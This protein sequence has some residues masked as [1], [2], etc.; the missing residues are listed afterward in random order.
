MERQIE[1][2]QEIKDM[3]AEL[4]EIKLLKEFERKKGNGQLRSALVVFQSNDIALLT[5]DLS[6][7]KLTLKILHK[8]S[9][10]IS[11]VCLMVTKHYG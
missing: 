10:D 4:K 7:P 1:C 6:I 5:I 2:E 9:E 8:E 11:D 3:V